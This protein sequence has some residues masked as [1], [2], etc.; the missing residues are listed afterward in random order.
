MSTQNFAIPIDHTSDTL[1]YY[2]STKID[3]T[4]ETIVE[5]YPSYYFVENGPDGLPNLCYGAD[6][7]SSLVTC[8][9][10]DSVTNSE[11]ISYS[12]EFIGGRP[13]SHPPR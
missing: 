9:F 10:T 7:T 1:N 2:D 8:S 3:E 6:P 4:V 12:S 13:A 11:Y 5:T